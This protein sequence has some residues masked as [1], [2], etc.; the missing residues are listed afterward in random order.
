MMVA[1]PMRS[2]GVTVPIIA[3]ERRVNALD[4]A[5][6]GVICGDAVVG[7]DGGIVFSEDDDSGHL[8]LCFP[9]IVEKTAK[10]ARA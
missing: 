4:A 6:E 9:R 8:W 10:A 2:P 7:R 3:D 1:L 5:R